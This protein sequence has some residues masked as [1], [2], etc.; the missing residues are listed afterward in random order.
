MAF[1][2][3][4]MRCGMKIY[5]ET[6][7]LAIVHAHPPFAVIESLLEETD[8]V[9]PP[10]IEGQYFLGKIPIVSGAAGTP[11]LAEQ[12]ALALFDHRSIIVFRHGTFAIGETLDEAYF[13]TEQTEHSCKLKYYYELAKKRV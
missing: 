6:P 4:E 1:F 11:E 9:I 2:P 7:A 13:V 10:N 8:T 12:T 5:R 3:E